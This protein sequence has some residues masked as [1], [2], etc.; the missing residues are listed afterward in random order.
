MET[1]KLFNDEFRINDTV[2]PLESIEL[3][4]PWMCKS[5]GKNY[6]FSKEASKKVA[7]LFGMN[8]AQFSKR[9]YNSASDL[10]LELLKRQR[11]TEDVTNNLA[12]HTAISLD[13]GSILSVLPNTIKLSSIFTKINEFMDNSE[14]TSQF[15]MSEKEGVLRIYY[16][17]KSGCG[18]VLSY[19]FSINWIDV[20][21][22]MLRDNIMYV[23]PLPSYSFEV[24]TEETLKVLVP[25]D[26]LTDAKETMEYI[27]TDLDDNIKKVKVSVNEIINLFKVAFKIKLTPDIQ[28]MLSQLADLE[29]PEDEYETLF[30]IIKKIMLSAY[31]TDASVASYYLKKA[32]TFTELT[33]KDL[34][35]DLTKLWSSGVIS[36]PVLE[37]L[38]LACHRN[39]ADYIQLELVK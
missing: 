26:L 8:N 34:L 31:S 15:S 18:I 1:I 2:L 5:N 37:Q 3:T 12:N 9:L 35:V 33:Y 24:D 10:W 23:A 36:Y 32:T 28:D 25:K 14:V 38:E 4:D 13:E 39:N 16:M 19:W 20:R 7:Y 22:I 17:D 21:S 29:L 6:S 30:N 11:A 27:Y